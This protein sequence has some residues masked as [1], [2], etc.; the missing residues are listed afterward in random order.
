[1]YSYYNEY[2]YNYRCL[3]NQILQKN[4][5]NVI[6]GNISKESSRDLQPKDI[7]LS[8]TLNP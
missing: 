4:I 1:M 5:D 8:L 6:I 2:D 3:N 7:S